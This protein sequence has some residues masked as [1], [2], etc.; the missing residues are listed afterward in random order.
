MSQQRDQYLGLQYS[1]TAMVHAARRATET[2]RRHQQPLVLSRDG[3]IVR[4][5]PDDVLELLEKTPEAS[6]QS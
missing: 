5:T 2:A 3:R 6:Q 1:R 4:V